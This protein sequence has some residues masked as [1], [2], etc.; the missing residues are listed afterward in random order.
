MRRPVETAQYVS[1]KYTNRL[2][3]AAL[4]P[5]VGAVGDTYDNALAE[6]MIDLFKAEVSRCGCMEDVEMG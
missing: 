3:D 6:T 5:S 1:S 4:E 2:A